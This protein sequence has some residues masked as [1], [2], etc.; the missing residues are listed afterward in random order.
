[1][2]CDY[3]DL[4]YKVMARDKNVQ[5]QG[6]RDIIECYLCSFH[7]SRCLLFILSYCYHSIGLQIHIDVCSYTLILPP[8]STESHTHM[9]ALAKSGTKVEHIG[10]RLLAGQYA[11]DA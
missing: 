6:P 5:S 11:Q 9:L 8:F 2:Q 3:H 1:M 10:L 7:I 4:L